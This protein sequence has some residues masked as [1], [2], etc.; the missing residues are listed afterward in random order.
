M[1]RNLYKNFEEYFC[2]FTM[3]IMVLCLTIQVLIRVFGGT[4]LAWTE[5]LSRYSFLWSVFLGT[6]VIAKRNAH[7]RVTAQFMMLPKKVQ[8]AF[9]A[10]ADTIWVGFTLYVAYLSLTVIQDSMEFPEIS[11]TLQIAKHWIEIVIPGGFVLMCWRVVE[12]WIIN[13]KNGTLDEL[14]RDEEGH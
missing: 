10:V 5:E 2:A 9:R 6:A 7:V 4:S 13:V 3:A 8:I 12:F 11:P 14:V 1:L